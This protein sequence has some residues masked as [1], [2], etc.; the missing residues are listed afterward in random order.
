MS[1]STTPQHARLITPAVIWFLLF[2]F[3][4]NT[5]LSLQMSALPWIAEDITGRAIAAGLTTGAM[6]LATVL[7]ELDTPRLLSKL[8]YRR[9]MEI[10][11]A[12]LGFPSLLIIAF[13]NLATIL[14]VAVCRGA[15]L[16]ITVVAGTALAVRMFPAHRR[17]EG[18]GLYGFVLSIPAMLL[19]PLGLWLTQRAGFDL[20]AMI[21]AAA[22]I[23]G[24][25][26]GRTLS[27]MH[28]GDRA[29]HGIMTELRTPAI[30]RPTIVFGVSTLALGIL[31]TYLALAVPDDMRGLAAI[32][33]L[34][35]AACSSLSRWPSGRLGDRIGSRRLLAPSV[36]LCAIGMVGIVATHNPVLLLSGM[37][38][39]GLGLGA[40]QNSSLAIMF[41]RAAP[42]RDAQVSV[43][44]NLAYDA[45]LGVGAVGFGILSGVTG[46][47]WG[48]AIVAI[49]LFLAVVPAHLDRHS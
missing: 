45:G 15:G 22:A 18:L 30:L 31:I 2:S 42:G 41:D 28:P 5:C 39:F 4:A 24:I 9:I 6:M 7:G 19:L 25:S 27:T 34:V 48:F 38:L 14:L 1:T 44:W 12:L 17:A 11:I 20:L 16:A 23:V 35:Q 36:F 8:G 37:A 49:L 46:F 3:C 33:L 32:G 43:V 26:L 10:G 21:T 40:A 13:P 29:T 47:T